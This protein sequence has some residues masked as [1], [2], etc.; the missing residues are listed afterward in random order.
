[1]EILSKNRIVP[2]AI[3]GAYWRFAQ[4]R[5]RIYYARVRGETRPWT[6]DEILNQF[7]FTNA[8]RAT[9]RVSQY[10]IRKV[11][12]NGAHSPESV[13]FRILLFKLFNKIETWERL[14][15]RFGEVSVDSFSVSEYSNFLSSVM[16]SGV[17]IYSAAYMMPPAPFGGPDSKK[18]ETH[19][20]LLKKMLDDGLPQKVF[21]AKSL[22]DVFVALCEYPAMGPFLAFQ[23]TIDL[24]YSLFLRFSEMDFVVAG[25]GALDGIS[26]CFSSTGGLRPEE[27]IKWVTDNQTELA[28]SYG[29]S[30]PSLWGRPLQ[31]IDCQNLFCEISKYSRVA[32]PDVRGVANRTKIKQVYKF[33][34]RVEAPWFPPKWG[35]N[36]SILEYIE[37]TSTNVRAVSD[38][39][40]LF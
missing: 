31:L 37:Q 25:P 22:Q 23:Y 10:L 3:F 19:L 26:K 7:K 16:R 32:Y 6:A 39:S 24:N 4:E 21:G 5:Q 11:I 40:N 1:M 27:V 2:S 8:F 35:I 29:F 34:G 28:A 33:A 38:Q 18:H 15:N 20:L 17:A 12:Y 36:G 9:D 13:F 30:A 14:E